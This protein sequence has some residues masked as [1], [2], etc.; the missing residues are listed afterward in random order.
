MIVVTR[1][2]EEKL[3][4]LCRKIGGSPNAWR[5]VSFSFGH[6]NK[7]YRDE[8]RLQIVVNMIKSNMLEEE[9]ARLYFCQDGTLVV[10]AFAAR[11]EALESVQRALHQAFPD[12]DGHVN[13]SR[14]FDM[15]VDMK[16]FMEF[17]EQKCLQAH[18]VEVERL[19]KGE[20]ERPRKIQVDEA[21]AKEVLSRR[22][23]RR[24]LHVM[25]VEDDL[26]T[27]RLVSKIVDEHV[28]IRAMDGVDAVETYML[29]A[30]DIV[31]LDIDLPSMTGL[32]VLEKIL[33][34]DPDA[35]VVMLSGNSQMENVSKAVRL[36]AKG[37]VAKP[38]PKEKLL[39]YVNI[40]Q[41]E[42]KSA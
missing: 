11:K 21:Y 42:K 38:F 20:E 28:V 19:N 7:D 40:Y 15:S 30:P 10:T 18:D 24:D 13:S 5:A 27:L 33:A 26:F 12:E 39:N 23:N 41:V 29:N 14:I 34:F 16:S 32:Q 31:F 9:Q 35:Y 1:Y 36:G 2:A 8:V 22:A 17:A 4:A 3:M 6:F 37:F 25:L